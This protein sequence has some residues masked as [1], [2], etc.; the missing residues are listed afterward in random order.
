MYLESY[1]Y[2]A[3]CARLERKTNVRKKLDALG[4]FLASREGIP[5]GLLTRS[6]SAVMIPDERV[7]TRN[8]FYKT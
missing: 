6:G 2:R 4:R 3:A 1:Q 5:V 8:E 7:T